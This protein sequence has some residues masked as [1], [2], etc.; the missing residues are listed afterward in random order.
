MI[1]PLIASS[2]PHPSIATV[3]LAFVMVAMIRLIAGMILLRVTWN[4]RD[5][6]FGH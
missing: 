1:L 3:V 6:L 5:D 2:G 4:F